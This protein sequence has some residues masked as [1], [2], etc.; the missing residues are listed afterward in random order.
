MLL[1]LPP[2]QLTGYATM[3][4]S[5]ASLPAMKYTSGQSSKR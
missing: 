5:P 3:G 2:Q 4:S 1:H